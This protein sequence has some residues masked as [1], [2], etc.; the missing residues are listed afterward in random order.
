[1]RHR[2]HRRSQDP[3]PQQRGQSLKLGLHSV[4][5][6]DRGSRLPVGAVDSHWRLVNFERAPGS[7]SIGKEYAPGAP[8]YTVRSVFGYPALSLDPSGEYV[9]TSPLNGYY[10]YETHFHGGPA[11]VDVV[12]NITVDD[13]VL[14][15]SLNGQPLN[16]QFEGSGTTRTIDGKSSA[17]YHERASFHL[18]GIR[19]GSN[20]LR[21]F[22]MNQLLN[23]KPNPHSFGVE[24]TDGPGAGH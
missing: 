14:N 22:T 17:L 11:Q 21:I 7:P 3:W 10:T 4:A 15:V 23:Y 9:P 13:A 8:L 1:M 19:P 16:L 12:G 5:A 2:R 6:D 20:V 24:F 18:T